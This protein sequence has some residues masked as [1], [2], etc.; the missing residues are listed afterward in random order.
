MCGL[1]APRKY[2]E[3]GRTFLG[4]WRQLDRIKY[5][6]AKGDDQLDESYRRQ[7][8]HHVPELLSDIGYMVY[9]ARVESKQ[10]LC[11]H[12]RAK[13]GNSNIFNPCERVLNTT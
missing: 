3:Y 2:C 7:P 9:R 4:G 11:K 13:V 5:R 10:A 12:V 1:Q 8:A 6:L